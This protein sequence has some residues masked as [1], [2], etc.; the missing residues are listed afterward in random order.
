MRLGGDKLTGYLTIVG[1]GMMSGEHLL[2]VI[3]CINGG[4]PFTDPPGST[5]RGMAKLANLQPSPSPALGWPSGSVCMGEE[6]SP[7]PAKLA[8]RFRRGEYVEMGKLLPES[9]SGQN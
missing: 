9:R 8:E 3:P 2:G 7:V 5:S 1:L 4:Q 6:I